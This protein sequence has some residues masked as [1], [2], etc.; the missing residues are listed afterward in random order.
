MRLPDARTG[1]TALCLSFA[2]GNVKKTWGCCT[3]KSNR[4]GKDAVKQP[5][6]LTILMD[7][8]VCGLSRH[9]ESRGIVQVFCGFSRPAR[10]NNP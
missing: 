7:M 9:C 6:Y 8:A 1:F 10:V 3:M 4:V 5:E 2:V